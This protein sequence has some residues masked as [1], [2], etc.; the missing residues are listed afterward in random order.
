MLASWPFDL[1]WCFWERWRREGYSRSVGVSSGCDGARTGRLQ[2]L[3]RTH[4]DVK[5]AARLG[6]GR[7]GA[8]DR[9]R[10]SVGDGGRGKIS[11]TRF[12]S[13]GVPTWTA[14]VTEGVLDNRLEVTGR[15][16]SGQPGMFSRNN[17]PVTSS[18]SAIFSS[19]GIS[20]LELKPEH[21][22]AWLGSSGFK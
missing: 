9:H 6:D 11:E 13:N 16:R 2:N 21:L 19:L 1:L 17:P 3:R 10:R 7:V 18:R 12:S 4:H 8:L 15:R 20:W 5:L 22:L 14:S